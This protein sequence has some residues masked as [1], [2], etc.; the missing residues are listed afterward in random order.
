MTV[1]VP[2]VTAVTAMET[3]TAMKLAM[4]TATMSML[5]SSALYSKYFFLRYLL[6]LSRVLVYSSSCCAFC[7]LLLLHR[8]PVSMI[9]LPPPLLLQCSGASCC[10]T[11]RLISA[12]NAIASHRWP[13][14]SSCCVCS[15]VDPDAPRHCWCC[16]CCCCLCIVVDVIVVA[17]VVIAATSNI[18]QL[19]LPVEPLHR[20]FPPRQRALCPYCASY[21]AGCCIAS[22][23]ANA[24]ACTTPGWRRWEEPHNCSASNGSNWQGGSHGHSSYWA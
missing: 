11:L 18:A 2:A 14:E 7:R 13:F 24:V 9:A 3:A 10:E 6:S 22:H 20:H 5:M 12:L 17:A 16:F 21:P 19:T 4:V 8:L 1:A 15:C 23:H